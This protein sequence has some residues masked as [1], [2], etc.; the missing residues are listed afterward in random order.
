MS[1]IERVQIINKTKWKMIK[2]NL[3]LNSFCFN[4]KLEKNW[5]KRLDVNDDDIIFKKPMNR[6]ILL[7]E[8][9]DRRR[10]KMMQILILQKIIGK[11][12]I[13]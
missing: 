12:F 5:H 1:K 13:P 6:I 9:F 2:E 11:L 8:I 3:L 4:N 7:F 10:V